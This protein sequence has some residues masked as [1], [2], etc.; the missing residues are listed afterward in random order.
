MCL[1]CF[2]V[3]EREEEVED[4]MDHREARREEQEGR[5]VAA[6]GTLV[7]PLPSLRALRV[8]RR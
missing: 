8:G 2:E 6:A 3:V 1:V 7:D 5:Q 4:Q